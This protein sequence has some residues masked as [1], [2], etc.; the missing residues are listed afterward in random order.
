MSLAATILT[1]FHDEAYRADLASVV[2]PRSVE[3]L[4]AWIDELCRVQLAERVVRA[5]FA[6]KSVGAV[7]GLVLTDGRSVVLKL[8]PASIDAAALHAIERCHA[9]VVAAGFPAPRQLVPLFHSDGVWGAFYELIDGEVLDAHRPDVRRT[10]AEALAELARVTSTLA[11]A[12]L[13]PAPTRAATRWGTPH[14][15]GMDLELPGGEWIDARADRARR[16][17]AELALPLCAAHLDW[18][19]KNALFQHGRL[20]AML[21]WDSLMQASEAEM[22]GRAAAQF[23]AQWDMPARLTPTP[24]EATAFVRE[25]EHACGRRFTPVEQRAA[26]ASADYLMAQVARQEH[27]APPRSDDY[28]ALLRETATMPLISWG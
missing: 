22:V 6:C 8:F 26:N 20:H 7:F 18:G 23:T 1:E 3:G 28:R 2:G 15:F 24:A 16:T 10:L 13:P 21:D 27:G 19:S 17:I 5:R 11:F 4:A 9:H 14:R 25:Y 12:D